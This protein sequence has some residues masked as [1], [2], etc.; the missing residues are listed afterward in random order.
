L[1][2]VCER[3]HQLIDDSAN[4]AEY[5]AGLVAR[6]YALEFRVSVTPADLREKR[7]VLTEMVAAREKWNRLRE[8][9]QKHRA[10]MAAERAVWI[11]PFLNHCQ[12]ASETCRPTSRGTLQDVAALDFRVACSGHESADSG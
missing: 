6:Y 7:Y 10:S 5:S 1:T 9:L 3:K 4:L 2:R 12:M 11:M 8:E